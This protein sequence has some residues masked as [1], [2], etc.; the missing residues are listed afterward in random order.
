[1]Y[2]D[3]GG[4]IGSLITT[5]ASSLSVG[6]K[7]A[8]DLKALFE[9]LISIG[10]AS[11]VWDIKACFN[12]VKNSVWPA[13]VANAI[14]QSGGTM[15]L[16]SVSLGSYDYTYYNSSQ[17]VSSFSNADYFTT[18]A[19]SRS[20]LIYINGNLTINSG[21]TFI[22]T[23]RK[24]F[25]ALYI[26]GNLTNNGIISMTARGANHSSTGSNLSAGAIKIATGTFGGVTDPNVPSSGGSGG[27]LNSAGSA[28]T[29]GGTGGGGGG[30]NNNGGSAAGS[31]SAGTSFTGG[32]GAGE[33]NG[34]G[35]TPTSGNSNGGAGGNGAGNTNHHAGTG[36]AGGVDGGG[37]GISYNGT[38]GTGGVLMIF[39]KGTLS[40]SGTVI[41]N[42]VNASN[43]NDAG[44][45]GGA[46]GGSSGGGS[47]TLIYNTDS[48][49]VTITANGGSA[50]RNGGAGTARKLSGL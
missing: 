5:T 40:G 28:G 30:A 45:S 15:T 13:G 8:N 12:K 48:S 22:P 50:G 43:G 6:N 25:T 20:A 31:G 21:Q 38:D 42:G 17:T 37:G 7:S 19:D 27:G 9:S 18:T 1:M 4:F 14:A 10:S 47:A 34:P 3:N 29:S 41:A 33:H 46:G 35:G 24:L 2:R 16:N 44:K 39:V 49:T 32:T 36:N 26:N 23:N 11:G